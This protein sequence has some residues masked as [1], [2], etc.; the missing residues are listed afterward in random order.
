MVYRALVVGGQ[1]NLIDSYISIYLFI[2][3]FIFKGR[4]KRE[5][6]RRGSD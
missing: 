2:Y 1:Q 4:V 6:E 3:L 5:R